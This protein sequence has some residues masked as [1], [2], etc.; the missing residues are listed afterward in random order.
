MC[1][2]R[3]DKSK[4]DTAVAKYKAKV[5]AWAEEER[6]KMERDTFPSADPLETGVICPPSHS[7]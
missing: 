1:K 3:E 7:N 5:D 6:L 2:V 4:M